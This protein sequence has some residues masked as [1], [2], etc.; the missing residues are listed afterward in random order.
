MAISELCRQYA[1]GRALYNVI[2]YRIHIVCLFLKVHGHT[3]CPH[4]GRQANVQTLQEPREEATTG[5]RQDES[6]VGGGSDSWHVIGV[7]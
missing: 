3:Q 4:R 1:Q 7:E 5:L 6:A 2:C